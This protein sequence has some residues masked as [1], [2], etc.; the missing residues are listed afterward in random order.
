MQSVSHDHETVTI[1]GR[2]QGPPGAA[3][4]GY[5]S[6]M[7]AERLGGSAEVTLRKPTPIDM[8]IVL[9]ERG[10]GTWLESGGQVLV[11][12]RPTS[13]DLGLPIRPTFEQATEARDRFDR[14]GH[15]F[16]HCFV[17]GTERKCADGL[18]IFAGPI[19]EGVVAAP[20]V[21]DAS[22]TENG[23]AGDVAH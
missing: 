3:N 8:P 12:A 23:A 22:L 20:W 16:R 13:P 9:K 15:P 17:C 10:A 6:G 18:R 5:V 11:A 14:Q 4:G 2:F 21:P 1:A 19:S 7:L